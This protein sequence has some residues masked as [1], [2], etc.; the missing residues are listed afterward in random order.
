MPQPQHSGDDRNDERH[1]TERKKTTER[2]GA[3]QRTET[4]RRTNDARTSSWLARTGLMTG[5]IAIGFVLLLFALGQAVGFD[6]LGLF[7]D[8][9]SSRTGRWLVVAFFALL[10]I[11]VAERGLRGKLRHI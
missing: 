3:D 10:L 1:R 6:L 9:I 4:G 7:A 5:L 2:N 8:A 11:G